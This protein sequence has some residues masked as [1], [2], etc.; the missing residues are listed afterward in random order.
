V[1]AVETTAADDVRSRWCTTWSR[2]LPTLISSVV[3]LDRPTD[4]RR[5]V[6]HMRADGGFAG[7]H[8]E[9]AAGALRLTVEIL[10]SPRAQRDLPSSLTPGAERTLADSP[11]SAGWSAT[12]KTTL[13]SEGRIAGAP[14]RAMARPLRERLLTGPMR[15]LNLDARLRTSPALRYNA[16]RAIKSRWFHVNN[17]AAQW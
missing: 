6:R 11:S 15:P 10:R 9:R 8:V 14:S 17:A 4:C 7:P 1:V 2:L 3:I 13:Y 5:H 12:T 16:A